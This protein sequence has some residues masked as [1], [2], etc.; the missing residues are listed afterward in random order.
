MG[1]LLEIQMSIIGKTTHQ[2]LMR[3]QN[4][5]NCH[6]PLVGIYV[7]TN[8]ESILSLS[9]KSF[10]IPMPHDPVIPSVG[11]YLRESKAYVHTKTFTQMF[12]GTLFVYS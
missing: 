11:I 5:W 6:T 3:T 2:V 12:I 10:K 7:A 9:L 4:N 1:F 8:L